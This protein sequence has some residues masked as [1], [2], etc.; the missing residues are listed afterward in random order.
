MCARCKPRE[1]EWESTEGHNAVVRE[2]EHREGAERLQT[3]DVRD[4]VL[5]QVE[6]LDDGEFV[7]YLV[8]GEYAGITD[9]EHFEA[10]AA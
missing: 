7:P 3:A 5:G 10:T 2:V 8:V 6:D 1:G 9:V 4:L